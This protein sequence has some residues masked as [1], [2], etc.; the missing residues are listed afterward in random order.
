M[1]SP[2][3]KENAPYPNKFYE[4]I[5]LSISDLVASGEL[6]PGDV[7]PSERELAEHFGTSRVPVREALKILE[8][9]GLVRYVPGRGMEISSIEISPLLSKVFFG[10]SVSEDTVDQ[11]MD[12]RCLIEPYAAAQAAVLATEEDLELIRRSLQEEETLPARDRSVEFHFTIVHASHNTL[13]E[14]IYKFLSAVLLQFR[15]EN[16]DERYEE[17]P[18]LFHGKIYNAIESRDGVIAQH[19]MRAHLEEEKSLSRHRQKLAADSV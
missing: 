19:L 11:L 17:G 6:K 5:I 1:F 13:L 12:I 7:L 3:T 16:L 9:L 4:K 2:I 15:A 18:L 14:E 8:F 10:M